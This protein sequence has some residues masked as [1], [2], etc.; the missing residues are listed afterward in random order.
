[1]LLTLAIATL[2]TDAIDVSVTTRPELKKG[3]PTVHVHILE[4]I[5]GFRLKLKRSDGKEVDVKGGG[6][7]GVTRDIELAQPEGKFTWNGELSVNFPNGTTQAMPLTFDTE[8]YGQL[9][10]TLKKEDVD[11]ANR[12]LRFSMNRPAAK[13]ELKVLMDTGKTAFDGE[14]PFNGEAPGSLLEVTWPERTGRI[15]K[16]WLKVFDKTE[17][18]DGVELSPWQIDIP[19]EEVQ[20][21]SGKADVRDSETAKLDKSYGLIRDAVLK[22]GSLAELKLYIAGHTDTVAAK[23]F[24]RTLSLNRARAIGQYFKKKGL[25]IS[26]YAEGFGEEALKVLTADDTDEQANRRADYFISIDPPTVTNATFAPKW[27]RL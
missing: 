1:M 15:M 5:A 20:F 21:D 16:I 12:K 18:F 8:L 24:N 14:V 11:L 17:L 4:P 23:D 2:L 3:L 7:P 26:I 6:R 19:H 13:A 9:R 27:Q 25:T 10:L 22:Y